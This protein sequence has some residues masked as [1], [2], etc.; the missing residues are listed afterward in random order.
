MKRDVYRI[1]S[2]QY[3]K[4]NENEKEDV[5]G[6]LDA[7]SKEIERWNNLKPKMEQ[8][9]DTFD[10]AWDL[11]EKLGQLEKDRQ[12]M[13]SLTYIAKKIDEG[14]ISAFDGGHDSV[15]LRYYY[16]ARRARIALTEWVSRN[17]KYPWTS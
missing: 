5:L 8:Y 14:D 15:E 16:K 3:N 11:I 7:A 17:I 13:K 4:V 10:E 2:E 6:G 12:L 1:L 9:A